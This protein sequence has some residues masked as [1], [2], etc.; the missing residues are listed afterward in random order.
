MTPDELRARCKQF[1]SVN[2]AHGRIVLTDGFNARLE[3]LCREM[4][5]EGLERSAVQ[6]ETR[7]GMIIAPGY[8][9]EFE[10]GFRCSNYALQYWCRQE[11]QR[12]SNLYDVRTHIQGLDQSAKN[13][14]ALTK[15][16]W[17]IEAQEI[18]QRLQVIRLAKI[19][20]SAYWNSGEMCIVLPD[21]KR[22]T[23]RP[24]DGGSDIQN[25][26]NARSKAE[27]LAKLATEGLHG[28]D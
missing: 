14:D 9:I 4:I 16:N 1:I 3:S 17:D 24:L 6:A 18:I 12:V 7:Q 5:V 13:E 15:I 19:L 25:V 10:S 27:H 8:H 26:W 2:S 23:D 21:G 11:A 22:L 20:Y 28:R